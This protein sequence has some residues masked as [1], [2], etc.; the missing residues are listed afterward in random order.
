MIDTN[1]LFTVLADATRRQILV[2]LMHAGES[3]VCNL[4]GTL[5][6]SQPKISRHLAVLREAGLVST[7]RS[8]TWVH[9]RINP[10]IPRWVQT[11]LTQIATGLTQEA[12]VCTS[13]RCDNSTNCAA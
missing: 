8:G 12:S 2:H 4:Y 5:D 9:Y 6:M 10:D 11:I 3:C 1:T 13:D 7:Q